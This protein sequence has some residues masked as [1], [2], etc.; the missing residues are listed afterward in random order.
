[1]ELIFKNFIL[2]P[3]LSVLYFP[4]WW[5]SKGLIKF[6]KFLHSFLKEIS[7][8]F[9]LKILIANLGKPMY[10]D[11]SREGRIISFFMRLF[12]LSFKIFKIIIVFILCFAVFVIY[13]LLPPFIIYEIVCNFNNSCRYFLLP[14]II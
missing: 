3:I 5:Y 11:C 8:P 4:L 9:V 10:G 7:S 13:L 6:F 1:M 14:P 2:D 12:H